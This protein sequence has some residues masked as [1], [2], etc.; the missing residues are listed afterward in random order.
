MWEIKV[1]HMNC[2]KLFFLRHLQTE[3]NKQTCINGRSADIPIMEMSS[4]TEA[5]DVDVVYCSSAL[6][7]RQT[8]ACFFKTN[9][10]Q[11]VI[12]SDA[13]LERSMGRLE[14]QKREAMAALYPD[15]FDKNMFRVFATPPEG[16]S[17]SDFMQRARCFYSKHLESVSGDVLVC[18]HNQFLKALYFLVSKEQISEERWKALTFPFGKMVPIRI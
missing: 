6:R 18:S 17:F 4:I 16:E 2:Q 11:A 15:L 10:A 5:R 7:C 14:G 3:N 12:Y 1:V 8:L 9:S 13:L